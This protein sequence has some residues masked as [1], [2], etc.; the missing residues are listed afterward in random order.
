MNYILKLRL[1]EEV[2]VRLVVPLPLDGKPQRTEGI[3]QPVN[4]WYSNE[5]GK[6][7]LKK[8]WRFLRASKEND[9]HLRGWGFGGRTEA[10]QQLWRTLERCSLYPAHE[11]ELREAAIQSATPEEFKPRYDA[12]ISKIVATFHGP[13]TEFMWEDSSFMP[14]LRKT[15][16]DW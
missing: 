15:F 1:P 2:T 8:I 4:S 13:H 10:L 14:W 9:R 5:L 6:G 16:A 3:L 11:A 12:I 7:E